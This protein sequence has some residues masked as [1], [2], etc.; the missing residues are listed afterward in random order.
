MSVESAQVAAKLKSETQPKE[1][2]VTKKAKTKPAAKAKAK[3][4]AKRKNE[5]VIAGTVRAGSKL[6]AIVGLLKRP[7]GCTTKDVLDVTGWPSVSMP[8]QA[9][10]AGLALQ[11]A[12]DGNVTRYRVA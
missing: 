2:D 10:A 6:E 9:K 7:E 8:Q 3:T 1:S 5:A 12:K 4:P 11:K